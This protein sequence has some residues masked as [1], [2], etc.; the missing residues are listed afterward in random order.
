MS[1]NMQVICCFFLLYIY[2]YIN[3]CI[4]GSSGCGLS[5]VYLDWFSWQ[6]PMVIVYFRSHFFYYKQFWLL[7]FYII[8]SKACKHKLK[9]NQSPGMMCKCHLRQIKSWGKVF[10][11]VFVLWTPEVETS[12][13]I[14][15][16][17]LKFFLI[18]S[19]GWYIIGGGCINNNHY[20]S[21]I[22]NPIKINVYTEIQVNMD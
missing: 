17:L 4:W 19:E 11:L 18:Q 2:K 15:D 9:L 7:T 1:Y 20:L 3:V 12:K 10:L 8:Q 5:R 13:R 21:T 6:C 14:P 16:L 22:I